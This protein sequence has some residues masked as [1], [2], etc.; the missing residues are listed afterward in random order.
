M[1]PEAFETEPPNEEVDPGPVPAPGPAEPEPTDPALIAPEAGENYDGSPAAEEF[2]RRTGVL[3]RPG[4][5]FNFGLVSMRD[6]NSKLLFDAEIGALGE[7][8]ADR[9][10]GRA[11]IANGDH[12]EGDDDVNYRR[13]ASVGLMDSSGLVSHGRVG[14][15]LLTVGLRRPVR[16]QVRQR[17][18][19]RCLR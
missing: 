15:T 10:V 9:G 12:G 16:H 6:L 13:E 3:P 7:A 17:R 19:R 8:L 14:R 1:P 5:V 4:Q 2:A 18:G 11:V